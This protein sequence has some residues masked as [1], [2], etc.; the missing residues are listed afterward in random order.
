MDQ[1][2]AGFIFGLGLWSAFLVVALAVS[3]MGVM[4]LFVSYLANGQKTKKE[5]KD[6]AK[7]EPVDLPDGVY[8]SSMFEDDGR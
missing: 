3:L 5:S 4:C 1:F 6:Q 2:V 7:R 8:Y